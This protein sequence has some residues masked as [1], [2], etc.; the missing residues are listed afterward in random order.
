M[1]YVGTVGRVAEQG[2]GKREYRTGEGRTGLVCWRSDEWVED[3]RV[4]PHQSWSLISPL[5]AHSL[6]QNFL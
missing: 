2:A 4:F 3:E 5:N 1:C 6:A